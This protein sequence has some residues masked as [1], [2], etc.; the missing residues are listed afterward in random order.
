MLRLFC[1]YLEPKSVL[2]GL[3]LFFFGGGGIPPD[4]FSP[5]AFFSLRKVS[6]TAMEICIFVDNSHARNMPGSRE[7]QER[8]LPARSRSWCSAS[9][10][11]FPLS[12][13]LS[14]WV[15]RYRRQMPETQACCCCQQNLCSKRRTASCQL[16]SSSPSWSY[17]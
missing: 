1:R 13:G 12:L 6:F 9:H 10:A 17:S 3:L 2:L 7:R 14:R 15:G 8:C 16:R 4:F 11:Y 5:Q